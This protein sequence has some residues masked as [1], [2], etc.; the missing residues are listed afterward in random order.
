MHAYLKAYNFLRN[1]RGVLESAAKALI[2]KE[3]LSEEQLKEFF[4][5]INPSLEASIQ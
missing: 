4:E 5:K 1:N 3:T 2:E